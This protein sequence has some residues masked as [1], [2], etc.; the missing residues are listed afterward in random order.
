MRLIYWYWRTLLFCGFANYVYE[1]FNYWR[2]IG[3]GKRRYEA[4]YKIQKDLILKH[5]FHECP[6][7]FWAT[8]ELDE[9]VTMGEGWCYEQSRGNPGVS[10][11][12]EPDP[13]LAYQKMPDRFD[14]GPTV[15]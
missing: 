3:F 13:V 1:L 12:E 2:T 10:W 8:R 15:H 14:H 9:H 6:H 5:G 7:C 11:D 4:A